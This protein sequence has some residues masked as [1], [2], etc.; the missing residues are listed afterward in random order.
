MQTELPAYGIRHLL[1]NLYVDMIYG[2]TEING[3]D[4]IVKR[5]VSF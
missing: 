4:K 1:Q 3:C 2:K 5:L